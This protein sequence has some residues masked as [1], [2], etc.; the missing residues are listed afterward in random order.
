MWNDRCLRTAVLVIPMV[1]VIGYY[2]PL[3][4]STVS[5][6]SP[7]AWHLMRL[8]WDPQFDIVLAGDSRVMHALSPTE[9][10]REAPGCRI[11]NFGFG[12]VSTSP[13]YLE[14]VRRLLDPQ[15]ESKAIVLGISPSSL[16][17][18][19]EDVYLLENLRGD[20]FERFLKLNCPKVLDFFAPYKNIDIKYAVFGGTRLHTVIYSNGFSGT[21][22][23][24]EVNR[25]LVLSGYRRYF[26]RKQVSPEVESSLLRYVREWVSQGVRVYGVRVPTDPEMLALENSRSGFVQQQFA[27]KFSDAG[28]IW[29]DLELQGYAS[30]DGSHLELESANRF[31]RKLARAIAESGWNGVHAEPRRRSRL[32]T[33][34]EQV[35]TRLLSQ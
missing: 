31:S 21:R 25:E 8:Q 24:G 6:I 33:R 17:E 1:I 29:L 3:R 26:S 16:C 30:Y 2:Q 10:G 4:C 5:G 27:E 15:S 32:A 34:G 9:I 12:A 13:A 11:A 22:S 7:Q 18:N 19:S 35:N 20:R 28:G 14:H 23:V